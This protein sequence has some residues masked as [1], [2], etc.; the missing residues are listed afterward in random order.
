[1]QLRGTEEEDVPGFW[2]SQ[3]SMV[4]DIFMGFGLFLRI[5]NINLHL[6]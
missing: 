3:Y 5:Q 4:G 1:M 2:S 6:V